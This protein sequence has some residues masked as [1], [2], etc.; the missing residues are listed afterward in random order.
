MNTL[1]SQGE[2]RTLG[3]RFREALFPQELGRAA[4]FLRFLGWVWLMIG[5]AALLEF[6]PVFQPAAFV[7]WIVAA[8]VY[9]VFAMDRP[10]LCNAGLSSW[11]LIWTV[12]PFANLVLFLTLFLWA[13]RQPDGNRS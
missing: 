6:L 4:Y 5:G 7:V 9:K 1:Q 8:L 3:R 12:V 2:H 13:P 10:R 11:L